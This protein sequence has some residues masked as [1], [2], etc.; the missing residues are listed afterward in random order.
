[1]LTYVSYA[2]MCLLMRVRSFIW[3]LS[4]CPALATPLLSLLPSPSSSLTLA[5]LPAPALCVPLLRLSAY[6]CASH[7]NFL[8]MK[9]IH[10]FGCSEPSSLFR[11]LRLLACLNHTA[12]TACALQIMLLCVPTYWQVCF[13]LLSCLCLLSICVL[14]HFQGPAC[15][16]VPVFSAAASASLPLCCCA[17]ARPRA[18]PPG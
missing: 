10:T 17:L 13:M 14:Q 15:A 8:W 1:M 18:L 7:P 2:C 16:K 12:H 9:F 6:A 4:A 5:H 3:F 11:P